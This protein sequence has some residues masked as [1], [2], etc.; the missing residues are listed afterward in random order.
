MLNLAFYHALT[1]TVTDF[2]F[3]GLTGVIPGDMLLRVNDE[4]VLGRPHRDVVKMF[5]H[6]APGQTAALQLL[7]GYPLPADAE[8]DTQQNNIPTVQF[9]I[10]KHTIII[11]QLE[12]SASDSKNNHRSMP[13]L[14]KLTFSTHPSSTTRTIS[15]PH[16]SLDLHN[17]HGMSSMHT[18]SVPIVKGDRGFGFTVADAAL[19]QIV[20]DIVQPLRF[21]F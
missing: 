7:R 15:Q 8:E 3:S 18:I 19:G 12:T 17:H 11:F 5:E 13:D 4:A 2:L 21:A 20:K 16:L 9:C 1:T 10:H 6:V 14:A